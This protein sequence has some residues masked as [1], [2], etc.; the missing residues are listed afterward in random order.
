MAP[1]N[2]LHRF[3]KCSSG[4]GMNAIS[5]KESSVAVKF[6]DTCQPEYCLSDE[7]QG[8]DILGLADRV[9]GAS[10]SVSSAD[11]YS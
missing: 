5:Q 3:E 11:A 1:M 4:Y 8:V 9:H 7:G 2:T 10:R 6:R